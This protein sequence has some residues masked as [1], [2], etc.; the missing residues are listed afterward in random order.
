[1][2]DY[3]ENLNLRW[4]IAPIPAVAAIIIQWGVIWLINSK[5]IAP[6]DRALGIIY[7]L[8]EMPTSFMCGVLLGWKYTVSFQTEDSYIQQTMANERRTLRYVAFF[9]V[10]GVFIAAWLLGSADLSLM[11]LP[12][13]RRF[14]AAFDVSTNLMVSLPI[15]CF[16]AGQFIALF[17]RSE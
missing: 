7:L 12:N 4:L 14:A 6:D 2:Q 1:M 17:T 11:N 5:A 15:Y 16:G 3:L 9:S 10:L 13:M 8:I